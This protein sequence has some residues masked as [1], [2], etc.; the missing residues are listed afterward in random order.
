LQN[1]AQQAFLAV[2]KAFNALFGER[3]NPFYYLGAISY[4]LFWIAVASGLYLYAFFETG[5][6][7]AYASVESL[8]QGQWYA[9]GILRSLHRYASDGLVVTMLLHM[10]RHF[11]FGRHRGWRWFSWISGLA[12]LWLAYASGINGYM[13][14]WDR[15]SQFVVTTTTEWFDALPVLGGSMTRNFISNANVSDRLFSLLSFIHIGL[16]LSMLAALWIHTQRT[17]AAKTSPPRPLMIGTLAGLAVLSLLKPALS[18]APSDMAS[19][20]ATI[21]FDWF[22]LP[23]YPLIL[24]WGPAQAWLLV[25][26]TTLLLAILPWLP[27]RRRSGSAAWSIAVH[28]DERIL[29]ARSGETLLDAGLREGLPMPFECRNGGCGLCKADLL[30]GEVRLQPYQASALSAAEHAAGKT[31]LC[32][33]EALSDVEISYVPRTGAKLLPIRQHVGRVTRLDPLAA[34]VMRLCLRLEGGTPLR[35]HAGQYINI[36]L[37][38]GARRSFSFATAPHAAD[39]IELHVRRIPGGRF[40]TEVFTGLKVGDLLRFEG[41]LGAFTLREDSGKPI[42]FVAGSTGFA[43]VKSMLEHAFHAGLKR[44]M[45]LYWGVRKRADLYLGALAEQW[46]REHDNFNFIPVLSA[47]GP[48]DHW[49]GRT[50]LV[51]EAILADFPDLSAHQVYACGSAQMVAAVHPAFVAHGIAEDDCFSD[52]F[53]LAPQRP[54]GTPQAEMV[55]LGGT[56]GSNG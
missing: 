7:S 19:L 13:L 47:P 8:T 34:D 35:F 46:A 45:I 31:L 39:E 54:V 11:T 10:L 25:L 36:V 27:G 40:T 43:P 21:D 38:D 33:A 32:C 3:L 28:P 14:P 1:A 2:E 12:L 26:G 56:G 20:P 24:R 55:K 4:F 18:Q 17:P 9:G 22:Y 41:P 6:G 5:L 53:H 37:A 48:E 50:G 49:T 29:T 23:L 16:P 30:R 51:H 15:L 42:L 44:R 52:A